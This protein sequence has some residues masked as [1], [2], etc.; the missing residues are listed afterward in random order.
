MTDCKIVGFSCSGDALTCVDSCSVT[1]GA[2]SVAFVVGS[3]IIDDRAAGWKP[4]TSG[5]SSAMSRVRTYED[6]LIHCFCFIE[7]SSVL[8]ALK[9]VFLAPD[10]AS[11]LELGLGGTRYGEA[12]LVPLRCVVENCVDM[13]DE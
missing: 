2:C 7:R 1:Y 11:V 12:T 9:T 3:A 13:M 4:V 6:R 10:L 5:Y 8:T